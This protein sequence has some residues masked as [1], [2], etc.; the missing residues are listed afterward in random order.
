MNIRNIAIS[1][2]VIT[3]LMAFDISSPKHKQ[4]LST[5]S[6]DALISDDQSESWTVMIYIVG[7]DLQ[8]NHNAGSLDIAEMFAAG[9]GDN[10]NVIVCTGGSQAEGWG[11]VQYTNL[12]DPSNPVD[13][14]LLDMAEPATLGNFVLNS[15]HYNPADKYALILWNHGSGIGGYG[16]DELS[17]N[18]FTIPELQGTL[19]G[20]YAQTNI[21][22]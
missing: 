2:L 9:T 18:S 14:G 10:L 13:L 11:T 8:T 1:I 12:R 16:N 3:I 4:S 21:K 22:F 17:R 5:N 20:I 15:M 19:A 6:L 7:S